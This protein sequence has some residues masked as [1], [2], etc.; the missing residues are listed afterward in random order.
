[1]DFTLYTQRKNETKVAMDSV[2]KTAKELGLNQIVEKVL[3]D[4]RQLEDEKFKL[5]VV[6]EFSRG[7]ST[8]V[9]AM[10]GRVM[11]PT[12][13]Q[14]TTNVISKIVY[15]NPP[16][17]TLHYRDGKQKNIDEEEFLGIRAQA[18]ERESL[19]S[20]MKAKVSDMLHKTVS[21]ENIEYAKIAYPLSF[22]QN[23]V[24]VVDTPGTNDLNT[25]RM[26]ITLNYINQ[27]DAAILVLSATQALTQSELD[28]LKEQLIGNHIE[29][30]FIVINYKD[31]LDNAA[32]EE[33]VLQHV[34]SN[35][36]QH[37]GRKPRIFLVSSRQALLYRRNQN[38]E[39]LKPKILLSVPK[40]IE[41]TGF[42][43][44][45]TALGQYLSEERGLSKLRK[46]ASRLQSYTREIEQ[47][48]A[49][50]LSVVD[51]SADDIKEQQ[52]EMQPKFRKTKRAAEQIV[53][54]LQAR[55]QAGET[56]LMNR[57]RP[58]LSKMKQAAVASIDGYED[59]MSEDDLKYLINKAITPIQKEMLDE[60]NQVQQ[61]LTEREMEHAIADIRTLWNDVDIHANRLAMIEKEQLAMNFYIERGNNEG[62]QK[63]GMLAGSLLAGAMGFGLLGF[64]A[65]GFLGAV[66]A[67]SVA[68]KDPRIE[69]KNQLRSQMDKQEKEF[70]RKTSEQYRNNIKRSTTAMQ[71]EITG[72]ID[73]MEAQLQRIIREKESKEL[74]AQEQ[75]E[76][77]LAMQTNIR[78]IGQNAVGVLNK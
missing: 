9:N 61:E 34:G 31:A 1:M 57:C 73:D 16:S 29:D 47:T 65:L 75:K 52:R 37:T 6:G 8:F 40:D 10:L 14:P 19:V 39:Q 54:G 50:K 72:R 76:Q 38:G 27:A 56:E 41:T 46:Y 22:C 59:G 5:V 55:L 70:L 48:L 11:L 4:K 78:L 15:G 18:E 21:F 17:Y 53:A 43:A 67:E 69:L 3:A 13:K 66:A 25:G 74:S 45:E 62:A 7:K 33:E 71:L 77:L 49:M 60:M 2:L 24:E 51:R 23:Q 42:P 36:Y 58:M 32:Q 35:I 20:R 26:E 64:L 63:L 12:S 68:Q 30:I 28:F 44:F